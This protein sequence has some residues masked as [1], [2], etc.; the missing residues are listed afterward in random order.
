M[1]DSKDTPA[2]AEELPES[3]NILV[4]SDGA[5]ITVGFL[6]RIL[7][8]LPP[9]IPVSLAI[10][11]DYDEV[12]LTEAILWKKHGGLFLVGEPQDED[13]G[14]DDDDTISGDWVE[15]PKVTCEEEKEEY[16]GSAAEEA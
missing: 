13:E 7:L 1:P 4:T 3:P 11:P 10:G 9:Q 6:A 8:T 5:P 12:P 15:V 14:L 16:D 2:T